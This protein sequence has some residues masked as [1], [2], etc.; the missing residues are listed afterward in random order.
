MPGC[1]MKLRRADGYC[2][3]LHVWAGGTGGH[4]RKAMRPSVSDIATIAADI[5]AAPR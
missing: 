5:A 3:E 1:A 2:V 4:R